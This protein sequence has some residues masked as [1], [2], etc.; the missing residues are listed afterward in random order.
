MLLLLRLLRLLTRRGNCY[1][2]VS[3]W[4]PTITLVDDLLPLVQNGLVWRLALLLR[5]NV[6]VCCARWESRGWAGWRVRG[7]IIIIH[8]YHSSD[9][10]VLLRVELGDVGWIRLELGNRGYEH[11]VQAHWGSDAAG[12]DGAGWLGFFFGNGIV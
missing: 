6:D 10:G 7:I 1:I 3:T 5:N 11:G 4:T 8:R 12:S 2:L 9:V